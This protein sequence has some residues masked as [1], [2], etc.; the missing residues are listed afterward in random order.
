MRIGC[1]GCGRT[2]SVPAERAGNPRLKVKCTCGLVFALADAP[3]VEEPAIEPAPLVLEPE[4]APAAAAPPRPPAP[5]P[6]AAPSRP[7]PPGTASTGIR[8]KPLD[9]PA[10]ALTSPPTP[11][12]RPARPPRPE[13]PAPLPV[14]APP[15]ARARSQA[16]WRRCVNH[17]DR[18]SDHVC[19][20]CAVGY[21]GACVQE[22]RGAGICPACDTLCVKASGYEATLD[23]ERQRGRSLFAEIPTILAYPFQDPIAFVALAIF[24]WVFAVIARFAMFGGAVA[25]LLSQGVL[26]AYCFYALTRVAD[27]NLKDF[28]PDLGDVGEL[29]RPLRLGAAAFLISTGPLLLVLF[30]GPGLAL[31]GVL[32]AGGPAPEPA[33]AH[34][35]A[36]V[37]PPPPEREEAEPEPPAD[38]AEQ[39]VPGEEGTI[40]ME[41]PEGAAALSLLS[42]GIAL[43]I[44]LAVVWKLVYTPVALTVAGLS[45]SALSTL[46]PVIGVTTILSMGAT[47]WQAM[48]IYTLIAIT[49][50]VAGFVLGLIPLVG[51]FVTGFANAYAYLAIGC[52]LG[53]AVFKK[54]R[55]LGFD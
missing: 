44:L 51:S 7:L 6:S 11:P 32:F 25:I 38:E 4:V 3:K 21:C 35:H 37:Q 45:R 14:A 42:P 8:L 19:R 40:T 18:T 12:P 53:L 47:Y 30:L 9:A 50:A 55:E 28:M 2:I 33:V 52:T 39:A 24:T 27:G 1:T 17:A 22:V 31:A 34:A 26:M 20:T 13:A 41:Q 29:I 15:P 36:L 43:M 49:Q 5:S 23:V 48:G 54:A 46:N 10:P 16:G